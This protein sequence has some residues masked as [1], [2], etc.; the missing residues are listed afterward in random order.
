MVSDGDKGVVAVAGQ[1]L[2]ALELQL[3]DPLEALAQVRLDA[4]GVLRLREDLQQLVVRE[5]EESRE[6]EPCKGESTPPEPQ[7]GEG[8]LTCDSPSCVLEPEAEG[9]PTD[10][11]QNKTDYPGALGPIDCSG[12]YVEGGPPCPND[13]VPEGEELPCCKPNS[14]D[15]LEVGV[16]SASSSDP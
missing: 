16:D 10:C 8:V 1:S 9:C 15:G 3:A 11:V 4:R 7:V 2:T 14:I 5:E 12:C 6:E 13:S